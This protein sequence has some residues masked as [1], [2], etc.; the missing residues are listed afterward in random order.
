MLVDFFVVYWLFGD[1]SVL[2]E[3]LNMTLVI[4]FINYM[5]LLVISYLVF[6]GEGLF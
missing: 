6:L 1:S 4:T 2:L 3:E 5:V